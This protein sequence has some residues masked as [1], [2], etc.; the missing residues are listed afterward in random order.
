MF[1]TEADRCKTIEQAVSE[2]ISSLTNEEKRQI[3]DMAEEDVI[4]LHF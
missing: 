4:L 1:N 3:K 2:M